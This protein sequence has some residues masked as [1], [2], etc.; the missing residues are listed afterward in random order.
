[1]RAPVRLVGRVGEL[2]A[3]ERALRAVERDRVAGVVLVVGESGIGKTTLL[4]TIGRREGARLVLAG[5]AA[6]VER[7]LPFGVFVDALDRHL[8]GQE[9]RVALL[10]EQLVGELAAVFPSLEALVEKPVRV[11][12]SERFRVHRAV[13]SLLE[14]LAGAQP[15]VLVLDDLQWADQASCELIASVLR[16]PPEAAV[17]LAL[18]YRAGLAPAVLVRALAAVSRELPVERIV[19]GPLTHAES[20]ELIG[21]EGPGPAAREVLYRQSGGNPFYLEQLARSVGSMPG[22]LGRRAGKALGSEVPPAVADALAAEV[23][24]L[25]QCTRAVLQAA[26]VTDEPFEPCVLAQIAAVDEHDALIALDELLERDLIR[27][28]AVARRFRFRHPLIRH[29]VYHSIRDGRRLAAHARAA[30]VLGAR[31]AGPMVCAPHVE[32]SATVGDE[33]AIELLSA[34]AQAAAGRAPASSAH[35]WQAAL[36]LVPEHGPLSKRRRTLLPVVAGALATAGRLGDSYATWLQVLEQ[37]PSSDAT[38]RVGVI[39]ACSAIENALGYHER[40]RRRLLDARE[41]Q[42]PDTREAVLLELE[43]AT[44]GVFMNEPELACDSARR[45][46]DGARSV[47]DLLLQA[48]G[49]IR[50]SIGRGMQGEIALATDAYDQAAGLLSML[51]EKQLAERIDTLFALGWAGWALRGSAEA[52][53]HFAHG[54]AL[55]RASGRAQL[56]IELMGGRS[57]MLRFLGRLAEALA[58]SDE[59][60]EAAQVTESPTALALAQRTRC[61]ALTA[62]GQLGCA[63]SAG[64]QAVAIARTVNISLPICSAV[65]VYGEALVEAGEHHRAIDVMLDLL[66]GPELPRWSVV[67]RPGGYEVLVYAELALGNQ[68][69]ADG[70]ARRAATIAASTQL[71]IN[72]SAAGRS[73]AAV[74][75]AQGDAARAAE[76]AERSVA[77]AEACDARL[78]AARARLL[79]GR[80]HAAAGNRDRAG[81]QLRAAEAQLAE[82]GA[83]RWRAQAVRELRRIGRRVHRSAQ[84]AIPGGDGIG[85]LS[86]REREV[87]RLVCEHRTNRE[88]AGEL[89]LSEKTVESHMRNIFVKLGVRTRAEVARTLQP[90]S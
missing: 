67:A 66:G 80:A 10:G 12:E 89:F 84:R 86:G 46:I 2:E 31:G 32:Q 83:Q 41:D 42:V 26:A 17:L 5:R 82:F 13:R 36:R 44:Y 54:L 20:L 16:R 38:C 24:R 63:V 3:I 49:A 30:T 87:A 72:A 23:S 21:P 4:G 43:L 68:A 27:A 77:H 76:W 53:R 45:A 8:A 15:V 19:L 74:L 37:T 39:A 61:Q 58:L 90:A 75:L 70:W 50:L 79:A 60:L 1:M 47:D 52:E 28:T 71:P 64:E 73:R 48:A 81:E 11:L 78:D 33:H 57:S 18:A 22:L 6:E 51:D 25:S 35:W 69:E 9:R 65:Y 56:L 29:A 88:I 62:S 14:R 55:S 40:A 34:A 7:D 59:C 85:A